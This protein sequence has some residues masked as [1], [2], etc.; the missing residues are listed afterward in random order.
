MLAF[1]REKVGSHTA[2]VLLAS[3]HVKSEWPQ[4]DANFERHSC[5]AEQTNLLEQTSSSAGCV[6]LASGRA[7]TRGRLLELVLQSQV[8]GLQKRKLPNCNLLLLC[9][10]DSS[11]AA[12][13]ARLPLDCNSSLRRRSSSLPYSKT[14]GPFACNL[15]LNWR[16]SLSLSFRSAPTSSLLCQLFVLHCSTVLRPLSRGRLQ[17][18]SSASLP[19]DGDC[20]RAPSGQL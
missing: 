17:L 11:N 10:C 19:P 18:R 20:E 4:R 14:F 8:E 16:C 7:A 5:A 13:N 1:G 12:S 2:Q 3:A 15:Q 6:R 9:A